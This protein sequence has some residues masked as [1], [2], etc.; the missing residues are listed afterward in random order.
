MNPHQSIKIA[1][2]FAVVFWILGSVS[3][4]AQETLTLKKAINYALENKA[5][6]KK[7]KLT[8][9]NAE[10]EIAEVRSQALPQVSLSG[11]LI[12]NPILQESALPG[13]FFDQP[14]TTILVPFGQEWMAV[15]GVNVSQ[16]IFNYSVFTG[17]KA[18]RSTREFYQVNQQLTEEQ[19]I[20]A[21]A[22]SFYHVFIAR[23]KLE[24]VEIT[25]DNTL[26]VRNTVQGL[27]DNGLARKIDLDRIKVS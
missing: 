27:F 13:E 26:K 6:A 12:Y 14:G 1:L 3:V 5:D 16:N 22:N 20:E 17:L 10:N 23:Q 11:N 7:A 21:V 4:Q 2:L 24:T 9:Q 18:A 15:G 25:L 8:A 19:V